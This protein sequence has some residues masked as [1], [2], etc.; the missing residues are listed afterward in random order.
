[1]T[2][3]MASYHHYVPSKLDG[4][5]LVVPLFCDGLSCE[6]GHDAQMARAHARSRWDRLEGLQPV[7]QEWHRR[8]LQMEVSKTNDFTMQFI[9]KKIVI[10][11]NECIILFLIRTHS[12]KYYG[13]EQWER[14]SC[15][16]PFDG[17]CGGIITSHKHARDKY[18]D[19]IALDC[20]WGVSRGSRAV[21]RLIITCELSCQISRSFHCP[22]CKK[23]WI[24]V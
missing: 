7:I 12:L 24:L 15:S 19:V 3:I 9:T 22:A 20:Y 16:H 1:M 18:C 11:G 6:R 17:M 10:H 21:V 13:K 2:D 4:N 8:Q 14:N 23:I 5:P